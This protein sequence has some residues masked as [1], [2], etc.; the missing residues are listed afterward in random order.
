MLPVAI[1][2]RMITDTTPE[3][4]VA[5]VTL[6]AFRS[7]LSARRSTRQFLQEDVPDDVIR[8]LHDAAGLTP[9]G[10]NARAYQVTMLPRG[11]T[12]ES[13]MRE[14]QRIYAA[15]SALLNNPLLRAAAAP[16]AGPYVRAFLRDG[17]YGPRMARLLGK[18]RRGEDPLFYSAP[19]VFF[20][21]SRALIPTPREDCVIAAFAVSLAAQ[22]AGLGC[23]LVTLA[24]S[25]VNAS[26]R[27]KELLGM[28]ADSSVH[29]VLVLGRA[30]SPAEERPARAPIPLHCV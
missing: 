12:R 8:V 14:L 24:Q 17:E 20:F 21:H 19:V 22:A 7:F 26:R 5:P 15:R 16:F 23:C 3:T 25:A 4:G 11:R 9:S 10:G 1:Q 2:P 28:S 13:L 6:T 30:A 29:A 18:L 27:C